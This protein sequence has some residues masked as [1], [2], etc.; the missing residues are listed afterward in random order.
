MQQGPTMILRGV[1]VP[2]A[3]SVARE[4]VLLSHAGDEPD[5]LT[6]SRLQKLL[7]YAQ[8][9]S[10]AVRESCLFPE[11]ILATRHGPAV[12]QVR[13]PRTPAGVVTRDGF[14]AAP[15]L[16]EEQKGFVRAVW[17]TYRGL[18]ASRLADMARDEAPWRSARGGR[19]ADDLAAPQISL[20]SLADHFDRQ[21]VPAPLA[22]HAAFRQ[23]LDRAARAELASMPPLDIAAFRAAAPK[24]RMPARGRR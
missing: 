9:W 13:P 17:N 5:P 7:Y 4:F 22:A 21:L 6:P 3:V 23:E 18:S 20:E 14:A 15:P 12:R 16:S 11:K 19:T 8:G 2:A 24:P 1:A 10:L